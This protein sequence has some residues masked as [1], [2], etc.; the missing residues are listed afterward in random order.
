MILLLVLLPTRAA[1]SWL[2]LSG[3]G[4]QTW[5]STAVPVDAERR[6]RTD[7][8]PDSGY[9]GQTP[10]DRPSDY[11]L[12]A[13]ADERRFVRY[14]DGELVDA[15]QIRKG[16]FELTSLIQ[17]AEPD[18]AGVV[19][20]PAEDAGWRALGYARSW[21][22]SDRTLLH[23]E[24]RLGETEILAFRA[25]PRGGYGVR[26]A[27]PVGSG[28]HASTRTVRISGA[29]KSTFKHHADDLSGCLS[30]SPK[31]V[32]ARLQI[33]YDGTGRPARLRVE[34]DQ[35]SF[36]VV[37]CMAGVVDKTRQEAFSEGEVVIYRTR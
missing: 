26:R 30:A 10:S 35:P 14:V 9:I 33:R 6:S 2:S 18:W 29:L 22:I 23:W 27:A 17:D 5:G 7:Y 36:N 15:W 4:G 13:P 11:Q 20:G 12:T 24:D 19:L 16:A 37:D 28:S 8:L 32:E 25:S 31:P 34:T 3:A 1:D 21:N